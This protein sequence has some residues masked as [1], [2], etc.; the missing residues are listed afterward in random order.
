MAKSTAADGS[1]AWSTAQRGCSS[2]QETSSTFH[3]GINKEEFL[4][5]VRRT[6]HVHAR[7]LSLVK[8]G[9]CMAS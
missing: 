7:T 6:S 1:V 5:N 8:F 3:D 2:S 4:T 9:P